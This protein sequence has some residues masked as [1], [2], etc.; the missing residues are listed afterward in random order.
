MGGSI[1]GGERE[2]VPLPDADKSSNEEL[3]NGR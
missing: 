2:T 3:Q 1:V